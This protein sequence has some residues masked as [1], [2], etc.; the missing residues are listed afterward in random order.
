MLL[1]L[2]NTGVGFHWLCTVVVPNEKTQ[3]ARRG[4]GG[5]FG[6]DWDAV[7]DGMTMGFE[8]WG[9]KGSWDIL[10]GGHADLQ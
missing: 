9:S 10:F 2:F 3:G 5:G 8:D 6:P 4:G 7:E 1:P